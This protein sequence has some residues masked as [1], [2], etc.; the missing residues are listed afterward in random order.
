MTPDGNTLVDADILIT[1]R[2][3]TAHLE[4]R[5]GAPRLRQRGQR[6]TVPL[7]QSRASGR[8]EQCIQTVFLSSECSLR[9]QKLVLQVELGLERSNKGGRLGRLLLRSQHVK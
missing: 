4:R 6:R 5:E 2:L 9:R 3:H 1:R 8:A 7:R